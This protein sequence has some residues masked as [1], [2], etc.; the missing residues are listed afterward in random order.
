MLRR[1]KPKMHNPQVRFH[2][3]FRLSRDIG[4]KGFRVRNYPSSFGLSECHNIP[5]EEP[6]ERPPCVAN[7]VKKKSTS[8]ERKTGEFRTKT[9]KVSHGARSLMTR[10]KQLQ[11]DIKHMTC[12]GTPELQPSCIAPDQH[13]AT[14]C[15]DRELVGLYLG[16]AG[17]RA[18]RRTPPPPPCV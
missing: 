17:I 13:S 16:D 11:S 6:E 5:P 1:L 8:T 12:N 3:N 9:F 10:N 4:N 7:Q 15:P 18:Q 14:W 2:C